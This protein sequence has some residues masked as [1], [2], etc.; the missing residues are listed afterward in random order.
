MPAITS[1]ES[2]RPAIRR[3]RIAAVLALLAVLPVAAACTQRPAGFIDD[4]TLT[5]QVKTALLNDPMIGAMGIE[6]DVD[7]GIVTLSGHVPAEDDVRRAVELAG[8]V[9]GVRDVT[10]TI[11]LRPGGH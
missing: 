6:V 1:W 9:A 2:E 4:A 10:T 5:V 3:V 11:Q 8:G 7:H